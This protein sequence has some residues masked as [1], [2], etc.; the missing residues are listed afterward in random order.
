MY[1][2]KT[3]YGLGL[4]NNNWYRIEDTEGLLLREVWDSFREIRMWIESDF[5]Q[6]TKMIEL[7]KYYLNMVEEIFPLTRDLSFRDFIAHY[8]NGKKLIDPAIAY[9]SVKE[10]EVRFQDAYQAGYKLYSTP[11]ILHDTSGLPK[12]EHLD[13]L[14]KKKG[15]SSQDLYKYC[16]PVV[17]GYI[18][19]MDFSD[20][21]VDAWILDGYKTI[22]HSG[23]AM[24]G[25]MDFSTVSP[26]QIIPITGDMIYKVNN[27]VDLVQTCYIKNIPAN[28][29][30]RYL[31]LVIA[32]KLYFPNDTGIFRIVGN[33][34][35][36]IRLEVGEWLRDFYTG[37]NVLNMEDA[38]L[39]S[40][41]RGYGYSTKIMDGFIR[42][43]LTMSQSYLVALDVDHLKVEY[44]P[45]QKTGIVKTYETYTPPNYPLR[46]EDGLLLNYWETE[47]EDINTGQL[48]WSIKTDYIAKNF[49]FD[50]ND[51][52][53]YTSLPNV[54]NDNRE[55]QNR[56]YHPQAKF[57]KMSSVHFEI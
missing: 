18:H 34:Q 52:E 5:H 25:L 26:L 57:L 38:P 2:L 37:L 45:V 6:Y 31:L 14:I 20:N 32:G 33:N 39:D 55:P 23:K 42:Y 15:V 16:L 46:S 8:L 17:N 24:V 10:Q 4:D 1:R 19:R 9:T 43:V 44:L 28:L 50:G 11:H 7:K 27:G 48:R 41:G 49:V 53:R 51:V 22:K 13:I 35:I 47:I 30:N 21:G 29:N 12:D 36:K 3:A 56:Y 54:V 40:Q